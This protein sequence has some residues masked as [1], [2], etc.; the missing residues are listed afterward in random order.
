MSY[1]EPLESRHPVAGC[2]GSFTEAGR[3]D[4]P[5]RV[6]LDIK[7][8]SSSDQSRSALPHEPHPPPTDGPRRQIPWRTT[9]GHESE[10]KTRRQAT[11]THTLTSP[12]PAALARRSRIRRKGNQPPTPT[13]IWRYDPESVNVPV[14]R[15]EA[16]CLSSKQDPLAVRRRLRPWL[17]SH[18]LA[19]LEFLLTDSATRAAVNHE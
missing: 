9:T 3:P 19:G 14:D 1:P 11:S 18:A 10:R 6:P 15:I 16:G 13:H 8:R 12:E 2:I 17:K 5:R 7:D 4:E